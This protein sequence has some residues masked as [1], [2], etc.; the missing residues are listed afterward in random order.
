MNVL[1]A[2]DSYTIGTGIMPSLL[3]EERIV[4]IPFES[5]FYTIG[6]I[7][8]VDR[9]LSELAKTFIEMLKTLAKNYDCGLV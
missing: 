8:R 7:L 2:T 3:N 1:L 4:S 9:N 6:Y 5:D